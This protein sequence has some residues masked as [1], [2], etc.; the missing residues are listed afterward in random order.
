[1]IID[2]VKLGGELFSCSISLTSHGTL[3]SKSGWTAVGRRVSVSCRLAQQ[4]WLMTSLWVMK[5]F[6][7][8][9]DL[10]LQETPYSVLHFSFIFFNPV[11]SFLCGISRSYPQDKCMLTQT[12][13]PALWHRLT[14]I[15][16]FDQYLESSSR[17][18]PMF[19]VR[20]WL[21]N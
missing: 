3:D 14:N 18:R 10:C 17:L 19:S 11:D 7:D 2:V 15:T 4:I 20:V 8:P 12:S 6:W 21:I 16:P 5:R 13:F 1:M 9:S